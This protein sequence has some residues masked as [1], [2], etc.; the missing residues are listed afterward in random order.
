MAGVF[1]AQLDCLN[2]KIKQCRTWQR[3]QEG[4]V[5][6]QQH[7][8]TFFDENGVK[9]SELQYQSSPIFTRIGSQ[10]LL[11]ISEYKKIP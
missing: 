4:A 6:S 8:N 1:W 7:T 10:Q 3:W 9:L 5:P 2:G 11:S